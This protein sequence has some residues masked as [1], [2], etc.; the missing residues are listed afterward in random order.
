LKSSLT[1]RVPNEPRKLCCGHYGTFQGNLRGSPV[2][3]TVFR[4]LGLLAGHYW[5]GISAPGFDLDYWRL[6]IWPVGEVRIRAVLT[7]GT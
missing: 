2:S 4:L 6:T 7:L 3:G 5:L 1:A